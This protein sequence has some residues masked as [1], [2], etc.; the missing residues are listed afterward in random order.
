MSD[1]VVF[2]VQVHRAR[3]RSQAHPG[4]GLPPREVCGGG[5][6]SRAADVVRWRRR[7]PG[8]PAVASSGPASRLQRFAPIPAPAA[9]PAVPPSCGC[10]R[11][12]LRPE[13]LPAG[14]WKPCAEGK[15]LSSG[16]RCPSVCPSVHPSHVLSVG[17]PGR[18]R[19]SVL[20]PH[21]T[22]TLCHCPV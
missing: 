15:G 16:S 3:S 10:R 6:A 12:C 20:R 21:S 19:V 5:P 1:P 18:L 4:K 14:R 2:C 17:P 8:R 22:V 13:P 9:L 11:S 7:R